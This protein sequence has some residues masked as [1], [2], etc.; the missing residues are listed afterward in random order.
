MGY[1]PGIEMECLMTDR[2]GIFAVYLYVE[3]PR[4]GLVTKSVV[5]LAGNACLG[6]YEPRL[7]SLGISIDG[8]EEVTVCEHRTSFKVW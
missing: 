1:H 5:F 2:H 7:Q 4:D 3:L 6:G 8:R